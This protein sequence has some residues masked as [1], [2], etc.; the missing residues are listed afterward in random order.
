MK[1]TSRASIALAFNRSDCRQLPVAELD[2]HVPSTRCHNWVDPARHC[3][4]A[5]YA[6]G[7]QTLRMASSARGRLIIA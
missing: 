5:K 2:F 1:L 4:A 6:S 7:G 3:M